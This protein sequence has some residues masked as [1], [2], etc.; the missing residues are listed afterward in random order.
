M[1][2]AGFT[3]VLVTGMLIRWIS[4]SPRPM[5][6]GAKPAGARLSVEPRMMIRNIIVITTSQTS[7]A[8]IEYSPGECSP[9]PF[10]AKPPAVLKPAL[11]LAIRYSTPP[12]TT[13]PST[14]ATM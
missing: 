4:V 14:C 10:E 8:T 5:A 12:A 3:E 2:R 9:K 1:L 13:A 7:A 11:P 6:S